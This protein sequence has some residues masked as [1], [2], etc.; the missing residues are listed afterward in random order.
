MI[1]LL[2]HEGFASSAAIET[3][4]GSSNFHSL[5]SKLK[6]HLKELNLVLDNS[7]SIGYQLKWKDENSPALQK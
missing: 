5:I 3:I 1:E 7:R 2:T 6:E 4:Y